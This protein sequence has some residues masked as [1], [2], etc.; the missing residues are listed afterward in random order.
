M[1]LLQFGCSLIDFD[2]I[3]PMQSSKLKKSLNFE[4]I[5]KKTKKHI[6]FT[7]KFIFIDKKIYFEFEIGF[8]QIDLNW[9]F[10]MKPSEFKIFISIQ[11]YHE[12]TAEN[13]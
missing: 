8:I 5:S 2:V 9:T 4:S 10:L 6:F 12:K 3:F 1:F 11:S 7:Y 13:Y